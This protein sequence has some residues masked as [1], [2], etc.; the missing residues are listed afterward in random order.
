MRRFCAG[1]LFPFLVFTSLLHGQGIITT[2]AG[3][4]AFFRGDG[5]PAISVQ[6]GVIHGVAVDSAGNLFVSDNSNHVVVKIFDRRDPHGSR[7]QRTRRLF[8]RRRAGYQ[9][10]AQLPRGNRGG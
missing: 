10:T 5:G 1:G 7:R 4:S 8:R 9:R 6:L 2:V 3:S